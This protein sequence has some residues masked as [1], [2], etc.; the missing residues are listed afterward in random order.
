MGQPRPLFLLFSVFSN[1]HHYNFT[2]NICEKCPSSIRCRD[3]N[4]RPSERESLPITTRPGLPPYNSFFILEFEKLW[5]DKDWFKHFKILNLLLNPWSILKVK[6]LFWV[7]LTCDPKLIEEKSSKNLKWEIPTCKELFLLAAA[8]APWY[9]LCSPS[10]GPRVQIP[11]KPSMLI[12][13]CV[14]E[15]EMRKG[16][17]NSGWPG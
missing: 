4:P 17:K 15:I 3:S 8:I 1:K 14:I 6:R 10:S 13:I 11:S 16:R 12:S 5:T 7:S 9:R 2:T